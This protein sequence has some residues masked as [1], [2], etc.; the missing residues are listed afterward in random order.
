MAVIE[1][2]QPNQTNMTYADATES[3]PHASSNMSTISGDVKREEE[4]LLNVEGLG[5][6]YGRIS[7]LEDIHIVIRPG[8]LV[9]L[10]GSNGA[11]KT[12]LLRCIS[13]VLP[14]VSGRIHFK[15]DDISSLPSHDR[16]SQGICQVPEGRQVFSAMSVEDNMRMGAYTRRKDNLD[17][18][19]ERMY[20][21]FP[22]LK[23]KRQLAAGNLSG[24]QQQMLAMAR[25]LMANPKLLLLDEP[26]MG[27]AP[28][29]VA[30]IFRVIRTLK[31]QGVTIFLVEQNAHAALELA[32]YGYVLETGRIVQAGTGNMLL[33]DESV[34]RAYL[35]M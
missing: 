5:C 1:V 21:L 13:G 3:M 27:L 12:T 20:E 35:G 14:I 30:E 34:Q 33:Q 24:G 31:E 19:M 7:A 4:F 10:V 23:Q 17:I 15:N 8:Q 26:S 16:V 32:D 2:N 29:L 18:D 6:R 28:L 9:A 25:A 11:G 22:I